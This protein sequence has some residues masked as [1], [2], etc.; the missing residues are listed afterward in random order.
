MSEYGPDMT[1]N[2]V[3]FACVC[4]R[5]LAESDIRETDRRDPSAYYGV[6]TDT[7]WDCTRCGTVTDQIMPQIVTVAT[8][9]IKRDHVAEADALRKER[10]G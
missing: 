3:R 10:E 8:H 9:T 5:F 2:D 4:G 7:E 1:H 6:S